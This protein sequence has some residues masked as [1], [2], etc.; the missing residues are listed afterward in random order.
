V[1]PDFYPCLIVEVET[2]GAEGRKIEWKLVQSGFLSKDDS[3]KLYKKCG[4]ILHSGNPFGTSRR[5][6]RRGTSADTRFTER[7]LPMDALA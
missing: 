1:N 7:R 2:H 4:T 3:V 6:R 5:R